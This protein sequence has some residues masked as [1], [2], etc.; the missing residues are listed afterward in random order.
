MYQLGI[1]DLSWTLVGYDEKLTFECTRAILNAYGLA[2]TDQDI[3][4]YLRLDMEGRRARRRSWGIE[5]DSQFAERWNSPEIIDRKLRHAFC[6][7]DVVVLTRLK[8]MGLKL[9]V[10]SSSPPRL[11]RGE[12]ALV[13]GRLPGWP[14]DVYV[15]LS[16]SSGRRMK[17]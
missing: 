6:F 8:E 12:L 15:D 14:F 10:V 5:N 9:T 11:A 2:L 4:D 7:P 3:I 13:E 16:R 1:F 17:P